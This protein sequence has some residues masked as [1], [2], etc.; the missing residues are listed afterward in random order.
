HRL[1]VSTHGVGPSSIS[2]DAPALFPLPPPTEAEIELLESEWVCSPESP[3][4]SPP[5]TDILE[6]Y[7]LVRQLGGTLDVSVPMQGPLRI[8]LRLP[9]SPPLPLNAPPHTR[10]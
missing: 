7:Q 5:P 9:V 1:V 8:V 10:S 4:P 3:T 2:A 6:S